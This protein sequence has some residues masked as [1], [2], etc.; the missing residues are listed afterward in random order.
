[1]STIVQIQVNVDDARALSA[2]TNIDAMCKSLSNSPVTIKVDAGAMSQVTALSDAMR[3]L[4]GTMSQTKFSQMGASDESGKI[5]KVSKEVKTYNDQLGRTVEVTKKVNKAGEATFS[6]KMTSDFAKQNSAMAK[7][8][9]YMQEAT[10]M[11]EQYKAQSEAAAQ[12]TALQ[13]QIN[14]LTGVSRET[15]SAEDSWK[16]YFSVLDTSTKKSTSLD[17]GLANLSNNI[18]TAADS[19]KYA[20]GTFS[21]FSESVETA[22]TN[23]RTLNANFKSGKIG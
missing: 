21:E 17:T 14:M 13:N 9:Q 5:A 16:S 22:K 12:P 11:Y 8:A 10:A 18:R 3:T 23:L 6:T 1:M 15:K 2:L 7:Q 19:G 20:K 4:Q